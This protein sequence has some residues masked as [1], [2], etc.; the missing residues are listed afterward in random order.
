M[1]INFAIGVDEDPKEVVNTL[2]L[3]WG[4]KGGT[5]MAIKSLQ[6]YHTAV[7]AVLHRFYNGVNWVTVGQKME[8]ILE[9]ARIAGMESEAEESMVEVEEITGWKKVPNVSFKLNVPTIPGQNAQQFEKM[10]N[11]R[12][13]GFN[14]KALHA[15]VDKLDLEYFTKLVKIAKEEGLFRKMW[16]RQVIVASVLDKN[17]IKDIKK[18]SSVVHDHIGLQVNM[19]GIAL[20]GIHDVDKEVPIYEDEDNQRS[21]IGFIS[22][23]Y[24]L[25]EYLKFPDGSGSLFC[26]IHHMTMGEAVAVVPNT[27]SAESMVTN[28]N[29]NMFCFLFNY[30]T[31]EVGLPVGLVNR[32]LH[33]SLDPAVVNKAGQC[34]FDSETFA[35]T[36]P[37]DEEEKEESLKDQPWWK[38]VMSSAVK[39]LSVLGLKGKKKNANAEN[40][41]NLDES[42]SVCTLSS[43]Q[44]AVSFNMDEN[45]TRTIEL[46]GSDDEEKESLNKDDNNKDNDNINKN[47]NSNNSNTEKVTESNGKNVNKQKQGPPPVDESSKSHETDVQDAEELPSAGGSKS[48]T[49]KETP[50]KTNVNPTTRHDAAGVG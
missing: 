14:R 39:D 38:D 36:T 48:T 16:G 20:E 41:Y 42:K 30:L 45:E 5:W 29:K 19:Q 12:E 24:A 43:N 3:E 21:L 9:M 40:L 37:E 23:R 35:V 22:L 26:Q 13:I 49:E 28:M 44:S 47:D 11:S 6:A 18:V 1:V 25:Y 27:A 50:L 17:N 33:K 7:G 32:L 15:E 46:D 10:E 8:Q 34:K 4:R 31:E 2:S